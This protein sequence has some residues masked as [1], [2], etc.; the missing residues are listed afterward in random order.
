MNGVMS[1]API[2]IVGAYGLLQAK[3][4]KYKNK[5]PSDKEINIG[6]EELFDTF[7]ND[8]FWPLLLQ[9]GQTAVEKTLGSIRPNRAEKII[10]YIKQTSAAD[11]RKRGIA[12][13]AV[14]SSDTEQGTAKNS[15]KADVNE[16]TP[17][18]T[19]GGDGAGTPE[20]EV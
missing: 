19:E 17:L 15:A 1:P 9:R 18:I 4:D 13:L 11:M 12:C 2:E 6:F 5:A 3:L 20:E 8:R 7:C 16:S 10:I 14:N